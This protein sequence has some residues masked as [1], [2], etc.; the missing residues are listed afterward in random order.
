VQDGGSP[1]YDS[2]GRFLGYIG[3]CLDISAQIEA[4]AAAR[5]S[6]ERFRLLIEG[7]PQGIFVQTDR[8]FAYVN[9]AAAAML[10]ERADELIGQQVVDHFAPVSRDLVSQRI[11]LLN[12]ERQSVPMLMETM[13]AETERPSSRQFWL[14]P[15]PT[16]KH[17]L[18]F[19]P[20]LTAREQAAEPCQSEAIYVA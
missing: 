4:V 7:A 14:S 12:D 11:H 17:A 3:H 1:R 2:H 15:S 19:F 13:L 6:E 9:A 16:G 8:R 18:G 5:A 10:G 20:R